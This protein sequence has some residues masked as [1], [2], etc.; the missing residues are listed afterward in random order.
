MLIC[1]HHELLALVAITVLA[2]MKVKTEGALCIIIGQ[3]LHSK[4]NTKDGC[5][6]SVDVVS[7]IHV[8][9]IIS[10]GL[11]R[12]STAP[13]IQCTAASW[14]PSLERMVRMSVLM[15]QQEVSLVVLGWTVTE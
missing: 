5:Q 2:L 11:T 10:G 7:Q 13:S 4:G 6:S 1:N 12:S 8:L 3:L 14:T 9:D 15:S